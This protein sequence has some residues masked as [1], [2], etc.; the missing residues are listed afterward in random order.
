MKRKLLLKI[1]IVNIL[2]GCSLQSRELFD[3]YYQDQQITGEV[4]NVV[5]KSLNEAGIHNSKNYTY[6]V[7]DTTE[8]VAKIGKCENGHFLKEE[9][10]TI[11]VIDDITVEE[12]ILRLYGS[13]EYNDKFVGMVL[14]TNTHGSYM[15][16]NIQDVREGILEGARKESY[17]MYASDSIIYRMHKNYNEEKIIELDANGFMKNDDFEKIVPYIDN[18]YLLDRRNYTINRVGDYETN[19]TEGR[20]DNYEL[21]NEDFVT[22]LVA[23]NRE[24]TYGLKEGVNNKG[25]YWV[26]EYDSKPGSTKMRITNGNTEAEAIENLENDL[27]GREFT[28]ELEREAYRDNR[29]LEHIDGKT[30]VMMDKML[31]NDTG[32]YY[33][34]KTD[35]IKVEVETMSATMITTYNLS[36]PEI[37][38][39]VTNKYEVDV[40]I[41]EVWEEK[42]GILSGVMSFTSKWGRYVNKYVSF[43]TKIEDKDTEDEK[44]YMAIS[45]HKISDPESESKKTEALKAAIEA[46][47]DEGSTPYLPSDPKPSS[48]VTPSETLKVFQDKE[49]ALKPYRLAINMGEVGE[50]WVKLQ[51]SK[52]MGGMIYD[53]DDTEIMNIKDTESGVVKADKRKI[54]YTIIKEGNTNETVYD[55]LVSYDVNDTNGVYL[56]S[57][58]SG[59]DTGKD[60]KYMAIAK[61]KDIFRAQ[62]KYAFGNTVEEAIEN[63]NNEPL[64]NL[65]ERINLANEYKVIYNMYNYGE[66]GAMVYNGEFPGVVPTPTPVTG[67]TP[68]YMKENTY[69]INFDITLGRPRIKVKQVKSVDIVNNKEVV[70]YNDEVTYEIY[71]VDQTSEYH[72]VFQLKLEAKTTLPDSVEDD[73]LKLDGK[74][75]SVR[76]GQEYNADV[77]FIAFGDTESIVNTEMD[78]IHPSSQVDFNFYTH[79]AIEAANTAPDEVLKIVL[80][81]YTR[82][83]NMLYQFYNFEDP[84]NGDSE[85]MQGFDPNN[86]ISY[87]FFEVMGVSFLDL[88]V[89]E[90]GVLEKDTYKLGVQVKDEAEE[91]KHGYYVM[92]GDGDRAGEMLGIRMNYAAGVDP[93]DEEELKAYCGENP[94]DIAILMSGMGKKQLDQ[95]YISDQ[96][97]EIEDTIKSMNTA[98]NDSK[99]TYNMKKH[100]LSSAIVNQTVTTRFGKLGNIY[101]LSSGGVVP[102]SSYSIFEFPT[103]EVVSSSNF[104]H[105]KHTKMS[106]DVVTSDELYRLYYVNPTSKTF[107]DNYEE[108]YLDP[109]NGSSTLIDNNYLVIN[110]VEECGDY[111]LDL[112][113]NNKIVMT[114]ATSLT[115]VK[116]LMD[117]KFLSTNTRPYS[118]WTH[119]VGDELLAF[120]DRPVTNIAL[121]MGSRN[122]KYYINSDIDSTYISG[123]VSGMVFTADSRIMTNM[124]MTHYSTISTYQEGNIITNI[125]HRYIATQSYTSN[126]YIEYADS[127]LRSGVF[128]MKHL[129]NGTFEDHYD[130][131]WEYT[132][133]QLIDTNYNDVTIDTIVKTQFKN[134]VLA[135]YSDL[136]ETNGTYANYDTTHTIGYATPASNSKEDMLKAVEEAE[137]DLKLRL[138]GGNRTRKDMIPRHQA[139]MSQVP[140]QVLNEST[141]MRMSGGMLVFTKPNKRGGDTVSYD[142][143][144]HT[145]QAYGTYYNTITY[146]TELKYDADNNYSDS[147]SGTYDHSS[148]MHNVSGTRYSAGVLVHMSHSL[149]S[150]YPYDTQQQNKFIIEMRFR[151]PAN[152]H[153]GYE[154]NLETNYTDR[155]QF[156]EVRPVASPSKDILVIKL[157]NHKASSVDI[158]SDSNDTAYMYNK[159]INKYHA[160]KI[161]RNENAYR[162]RWIMKD[163]IADAV[164]CAQK[165]QN[166]MDSSIDTHLEYNL[167]PIYTASEYRLHFMNYNYYGQFHQTKYYIPSWEWSYNDA[168]STVFQYTLYWNNND[169]SSGLGW[170]KNDTGLAETLYWPNNGWSRYNCVGIHF[171]RKGWTDNHVSFRLAETYYKHNTYNILWATANDTDSI[172]VQAG[173][174]GADRSMLRYGHQDKYIAMRRVKMLNYNGENFDGKLLSINR[175]YMHNDKYD[176]WRSLMWGFYEGTDSDN[177]TYAPASGPD[178]AKTINGSSNPFNF[179]N[180]R[181]DVYWAEWFKA[182]NSDPGDIT[183]F[184]S[185]TFSDNGY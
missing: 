173:T 146:A 21:E 152:I 185:G 125:N 115:T 102:A 88:Y 75:M 118:Y 69:N 53:P 149:D 119:E 160:V 57:Y 65:H 84:V 82:N 148:L 16:M 142:G 4:D 86:Y 8:K 150:L 175:A 162:Y 70:T 37:E 49:S 182:H 32:E 116:N 47:V 122:Y 2:A 151:P 183:G 153:P 56:L 26:I 44:T 97:D 112:E 178:T 180:Y 113:K 60:G 78:R 41:E 171:N 58:E 29:G 126:L 74:Y 64:H 28:H 7:F 103:G 19:E 35:E 89:M 117:T 111:N 130:K 143:W 164:T 14:L 17:W 68:M 18:E 127:A 27:E 62:A 25:M 158:I 165:T 63:R 137:K 157:Y 166:S 135:V 139:Y 77:A 72:G 93:S 138:T 30:M 46:L 11:E 136:G 107:A 59:A 73:E 95:R 114:N 40:R 9:A 167:R 85:I 34:E 100:S 176:R 71:A 66:W 147:Y 106:K 145:G 91:Y 109:V 39:G 132:V 99:L 168:S 42:S 98:L 12:G 169:G 3:M 128:R 163:T 38:N 155:Q 67:T 110:L 81:Y 154:G 123:N 13:G 156:F 83:N 170:N 79:R 80:E 24:I 61:G 172:Y 181:Y 177:T 31:I 101:S 52:E 48:S 134:K 55:V 76:L 120:D 96:G 174:G 5:Y 23:P 22:K 124:K 184:E 1:M 131:D 104:I 90:E 45:L 129:K 105:L 20:Y 159:L 6:W 144:S 36:T 121:K 87:N 43:R 133:I 179:K 141:R 161:G 50:Y 33:W 140:L 108:Y 15:K 51:Y 94:R 10:Y 92:F 54:E